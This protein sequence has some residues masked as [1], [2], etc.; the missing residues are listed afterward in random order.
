M[1]IIDVLRDTKNQAIAAIAKKFVNAMI[2]DYGEMVNLQIDSL[3]KTIRLEVL[4]KGEQESVFLTINNYTIVQ[5]G[6]SFFL[7]FKTI[8][9][10]REWIDAAIQN[11]VIPRIAPLRQLKIESQYAKIIDLLV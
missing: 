11:I 6:D 8:S 5:Q 2:H 4:L 7:E 3:N 9:A 10:S 1:S